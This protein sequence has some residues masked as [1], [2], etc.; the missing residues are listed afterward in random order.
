MPSSASGCSRKMSRPS[1]PATAQPSSGSRLARL[2]AEEDF[3]PPWPAIAHPGVERLPAPA[4]A[5]SHLACCFPPSQGCQPASLPAGPAG[6]CFCRETKQVVPGQPRRFLCQ[7]QQG[8]SVG[9]AAP[10]L[11]F[12]L[13][14]AAGE[15]AGQPEGLADLAPLHLGRPS[16]IL[17]WSSCS[18]WPLLHLAHRLSPSQGSIFLLPPPIYIYIYM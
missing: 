17:G 4:I 16:P 1:L 7:R 10:C 12:M 14:P 18:C 9:R 11:P 13:R 8:E 6:V 15:R 3:S 2:C 5:P